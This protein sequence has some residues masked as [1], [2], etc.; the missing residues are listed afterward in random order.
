MIKNRGRK[1]MGFFDVL[2]EV[3]GLVVR[4]TGTVLNEVAKE[5]IGVD[6]KDEINNYKQEAEW[7]SGYKKDLEDNAKKYIEEGGYDEYQ[8]ELDNLKKHGQL[9]SKMQQDRIRYQVEGK[10]TIDCQRMY[11][12]RLKEV[13]TRQLQY[14]LYNCDYPEPLRQV[15]YRELS[16]R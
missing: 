14:M 11:G 15:I 8:E 3:A 7:Y 4:G 12:D 2:G 16:R 5:A 10:M 9:W 1:S 13:S 6:I